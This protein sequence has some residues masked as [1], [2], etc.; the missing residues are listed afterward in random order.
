MIPDGTFM[1]ATA[2][3]DVMTVSL[4]IKKYDND[5]NNTA[6]WI[7]SPS[8]PGIRGFQA[9]VP[10]I[11]ETV[12]FDVGGTVPDDSE[13]SAPIS[14]FPGYTD[15]SWWTNWHHWTFIKNGSTKQIWIDGQ[16]FLEGTIGATALPTDLSRIWLGADASGQGGVTGN[17]HG[18]IDD[19]AIFGTALTQAQ[20][21]QLFSGTLPS[22][23]P[24]STKPLAYWDFSAPAVVV[25]PPLTVGRTGNAVTIS[26]P[27]S[28][29]GFR[30]RSAPVVTGPFSDV[31]GVTGNSYTIN[32][33]SGAVFYLLQQN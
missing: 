3:N 21:G 14:T 1:R 25:R 17:M 5:V 33:P 29:T 11:D 31:Q 27:A 23:L 26:W 30:L 6:F 24:A 28:A 13:I 18:L 2:S 7:E 20:V 4:W 10:L 9:T 16:L 8:S 12:V 32:N 22:A 15:A 19:F